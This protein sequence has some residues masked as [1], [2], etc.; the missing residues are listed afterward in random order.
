M[1]SFEGDS[2]SV[3]PPD[4]TNF[5][6]LTRGVFSP[7]SRTTNFASGGATIA[8]LTSRAASVDATFDAT[9]FFNVLVVFVGTNDLWAGRTATQ[10]FDDLKAYCE[11]RQ[12][13][14]W[15]VVVGTI[16]PRLDS[17][18]VSLGFNTKRNA[19]NAAIR[20]DSSFYDALADVGDTA[21]T[22]GADS[23]PNDTSLWEIDKTHPLNPAGQALLAP[24]FKAAV[25]SL[26]PAVP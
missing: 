11:A 13:A 12:T 15:K 25:R 24:A 23:S 19:V 5:V 17:V 7:Y 9:R 4:Y 2:I 16:L 14:G 10:V 21:T 22:M 20:A 1:L 26:I 18:S 8:T 6:E 3:W